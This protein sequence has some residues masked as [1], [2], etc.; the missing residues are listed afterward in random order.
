VLTCGK[1]A[2]GDQTADGCGADIE[3]FGGLVKRRPAALGALAL[4]IDG[5]VTVFPQRGDS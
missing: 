2:V 3:R 1:C 5:D 4:S